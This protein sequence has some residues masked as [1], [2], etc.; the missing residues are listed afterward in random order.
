VD[1]TQD[2]AAIGHPWPV[3]VVQNQKIAAFGSSYRAYAI[4]L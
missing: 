3:A 2:L 4:P 1:L